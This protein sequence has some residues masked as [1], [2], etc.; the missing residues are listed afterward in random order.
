MIYAGWLDESIDDDD[1]FE[2]G[3][4]NYD[5]DEVVGD[6]DDISYQANAIEEPEDRPSIQRAFITNDEGNSVTIRIPN[7]RKKIEKSLRGA[8]IAA[9]ADKG[10]YDE[11]EIG[12][13][14]FNKAVRQAFRKLDNGE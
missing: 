6:D 13:E 2:R 8:I 9:V 10:G 11:D 7:I 12:G 4:A 1:R 5:D 3:F 14:V